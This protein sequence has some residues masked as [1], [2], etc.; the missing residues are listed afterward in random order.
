[1]NYLI[2]MLI[3]VGS[4]NVTYQP[5]HEL[6]EAASAY[7]WP[8]VDSRGIA[9]GESYHRLT[10]WNGFDAGVWQINEY[11]WR[12]V[13]GENVWAQRFTARGSAHM[14]YHVWETGGDSF[15]WWSCGK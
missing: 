8:G 5:Q 14:A 6:V 9:W 11:W 2:W 3:D 15:R 1:M 13:F 10:A 7:P 4:M 12:H